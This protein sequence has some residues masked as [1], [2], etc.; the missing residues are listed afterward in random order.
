MLPPMVKLLTLIVVILQLAIMPAFAVDSCERGHACQAEATAKKQQDQQD[1]KLAKA[2]HCCGC[3]Q[4]SDRAHSSPVPLIRTSASA[5][6]PMMVQHF[7]PS[8]SPGPLLEPP[9]HV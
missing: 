8:F 1:D 2:A 7:L 6:I 5:A 4:M 3:H 9:S